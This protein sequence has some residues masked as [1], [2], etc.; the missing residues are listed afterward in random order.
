MTNGEAIQQLL[1]DGPMSKDDLFAKMMS[2]WGVAPVIA[3]SVLVSMEYRKE[4]VIRDGMV[5]L[6]GG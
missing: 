2:S 1:A 5:E 4:I 3:N 6:A